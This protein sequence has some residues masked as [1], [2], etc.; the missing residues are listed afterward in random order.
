M[1]LTENKIYMS[2]ELCS[3]VHIAE[4]ASVMIFDEANILEKVTFG[5]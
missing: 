5:E 1:N 2:D 4:G 3:E